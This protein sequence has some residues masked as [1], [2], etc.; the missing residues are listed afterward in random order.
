MLGFIFVPIWG[1]GE[2]GERG[3][4]FCFCSPGIQLM[5]ICI[6]Y[7]TWQKHCGLQYLQSTFPVE[8]HL[9]PNLWHDVKH[10]FQIYTAHLASFQVLTSQAKLHPYIILIGIQKT[11]IYQY[12]DIIILIRL[13]FNLKLMS[14]QDKLQIVLSKVKRCRDQCLFNENHAFCLDCLANHFQCLKTMFK[15][16]L[17]LVLPFFRKIKNHIS[18]MYINTPSFL[19][20]SP[21]LCL[22]HCFV[23][24]LICF[25]HYL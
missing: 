6:C 20:L 3:E 24:E 12:F 15:Q 17:I 21:V 25:K 8:L 18:I 22:F 10:D 9:V 2:K 16:G 4:V 19:R 14:T 5:Q 7:L 11:I 23:A 1:G 13:T